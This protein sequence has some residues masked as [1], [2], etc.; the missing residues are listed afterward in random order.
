MCAADNYINSIV[1][2]LTIIVMQADRGGVIQYQFNYNNSLAFTLVT[3][4][5]LDSGKR[6]RE[7]LVLVHGNDVIIYTS[8]L[9]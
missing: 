7:I 8:P 1:Q 4:F 9:I 3:H 6:E 2:R 5:S